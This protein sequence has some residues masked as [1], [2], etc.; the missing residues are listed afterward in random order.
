[1]FPH[2]WIQNKE[3]LV[4]S[5]CIADSR[6]SKDLRN[7]QE[8]SV[9]IHDVNPRYQKFDFRTYFI[10]RKIETHWTQQLPHQ[11]I[12]IILYCIETTNRF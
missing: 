8:Y 4:V 2:K 10:G 9:F 11:V 5:C 12:K 6:P 3:A 1:M 7:S